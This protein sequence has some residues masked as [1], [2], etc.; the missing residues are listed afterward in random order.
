MQNGKQERVKAGY[1]H[2]DG[3]LPF[4]LRSLCTERLKPLYLLRSAQRSAP[5]WRRTCHPHKQTLSRCPPGR[6]VPPAHNGA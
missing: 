2:G 1:H 5:L 6:A 3:T 4:V